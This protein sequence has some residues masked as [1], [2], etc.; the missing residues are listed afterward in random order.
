MI[1]KQIK[2]LITLRTDKKVRVFT[3]EKISSA[4]GRSLI[5]KVF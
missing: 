5:L 4:S 1:Y 3:A 2:L